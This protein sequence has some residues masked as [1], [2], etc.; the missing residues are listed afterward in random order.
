MK[1]L[2]QILNLVII[3]YVPEMGT[4]ASLGHKKYP[5]SIAILIKQKDYIIYKCQQKCLIND[6]FDTFQVQSQN[7]TLVGSVNAV[8]LLKA[9]LWL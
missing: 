9:L 4:F 1:Y 3:S 8:F 6:A 7:Q 2:L 5:F